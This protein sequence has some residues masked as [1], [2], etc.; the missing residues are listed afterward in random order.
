[1]SKFR[2]IITDLFSGSVKGTNNAESAREFSECDEF[3]VVDIEATNGPVW[4][5]NGE[6]H[7]IEAMKDED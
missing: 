1:M 2:F 3:F 7:E 6:A 5:V 4:V